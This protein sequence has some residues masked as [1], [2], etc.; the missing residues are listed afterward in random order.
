MRIILASK[1]PRRSEILTNIGARYEV[2]PSDADESIAEGTSPVDA[3]CEI[4]RRKARQ[5]SKKLSSED[6]FVISADTVVVY[7]GRIIGKPSDEEA[8][9][10]TLG[11]L[12]GT[13]HEVYTGFT[14]CRGE[15]S[16]TSHVSTKVYFRELS[17]EDIRAY[18]ASGEPM[19]KAGAYGIQE[20]GSVFVEKI[21]GD[22]FNVM[23]LPVCA[24]CE[25][26]KREFGIALENF[27]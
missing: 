10:R 14:L 22:Y 7:G 2:M 21:D 5:I 25:A 6:V 17:D 12:S 15:K 16:Y 26:A 19:D 18:V 4:S 8:A 24:L 13:V 9:R 23:G 20:K 27:D 3:V 1:S 11:L